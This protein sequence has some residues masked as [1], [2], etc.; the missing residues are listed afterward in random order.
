MILKDKPR[1]ADVAFLEQG[2][3]AAKAVARLTLKT[4]T[5]SES[6]ATAFLIANDRIV[7]V[8]HALPQDSTKW[9]TAACSVLFD[10]AWGARNVPLAAVRRS[11]D[12]TSVVANMGHDWALLRLDSP[13]PKGFP[14]LRLGSSRPLSIRDPVYI[15]QHPYGNMKKIAFPYEGIKFEDDARIHYDVDTAPGASGAPV[16]NED[17]EVVAIHHR[18]VRIPESLTG[19]EL[20]NV[21]IRIERVMDELHAAGVDVEDSLSG[22]KT[23]RELLY[24]SFHPNDR[25]V[26]D[27]LVVHL[28]PLASARDLI[29][30][31]QGMTAPGADIQ[32]ES[33]RHL[34]TATIAVAVLSPD[35]LNC[36][37]AQSELIFELAKQNSI[38]A[39]AL[40]ARPCSWEFSGFV[41]KQPLPFD[42]RSLSQQSDTE[43]AYVDV[44]R[45]LGAM[46]SDDSY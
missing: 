2:A 19:G 41:G 29:I 6:H 25:A 36:C 16:F 22:S 42:G 28:G 27:N 12:L 4:E 32:G 38:K 26:V 11:C 46:L 18:Y 34:R 31:H 37:R 35:Y 5:G 15:I 8:A 24:I 13:V 14:T 30:W 33:D 10:Y 44:S 45:A 7:T 3:R 9:P 20:R 23:A 40:L 1:M 39:V 17:W 43:Q 21:G